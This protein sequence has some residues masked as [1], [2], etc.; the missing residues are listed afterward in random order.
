M[1]GSVAAAAAQAAAPF[2]IVTSIFRTV[3]HNRAVGGV[4]DSYHLLGRAIDIVRRSGI[5]HAQ[6][7]AALRAAGYVIVESLDEGGHSHFAFA[8]APQQANQAPKQSVAAI[9]PRVMSDEH[10][11]LLFDLAP[12]RDFAASPGARH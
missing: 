5:T 2:G 6:I 11:T 9:K 1:E 3:A 4:P 12:Q 8:S 10:G 7:A